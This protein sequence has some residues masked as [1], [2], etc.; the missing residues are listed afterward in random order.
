MFV[1]QRKLLR[2]LTVCGEEIKL[3][4]YADDTTL[5]LD[6]SE[7]SL[8]ESLKLLD[9]FGKMSGLKRELW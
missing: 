2:G 6:G 3:S 5:I 9:D 7:E 8:R 4:Q 1:K